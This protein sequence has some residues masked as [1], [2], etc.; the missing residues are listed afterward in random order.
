MQ[1]AS[2]A[3]PNFP[4]SRTSIPMRA[5]IE[6]MNELAVSVGTHAHCH[7]MYMIYTVYTQHDPALGHQIL[8]TSGPYGP[9]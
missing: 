3:M 1:P 8:A 6:T 2:K 5:T 4:G 7:N 9:P